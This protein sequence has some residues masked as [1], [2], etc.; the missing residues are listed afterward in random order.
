VSQARD[1][2]KQTEVYNGVDLTTNARF[3]HG[4]QVS[5]GHGASWLQPI[6][7]QPGRALVLST[8]LDF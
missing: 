2:G 6:L 7:V 8:Q 3:A 5:G 1:F 4:V